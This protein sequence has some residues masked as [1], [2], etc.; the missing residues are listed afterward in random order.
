M[1]VTHHSFKQGILFFVFIILPLIGI[2]YILGIF[3]DWD[4]Y[5]MVIIG[6][7]LIILAYRNLPDSENEDIKEQ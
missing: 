5:S 4:S 7:F 3:S 1:D 6:V 2:M